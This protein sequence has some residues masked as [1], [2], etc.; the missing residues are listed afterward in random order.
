MSA[1]RLHACSRSTGS[2]TSVCSSVWQ[3]V[4]KLPSRV[5]CSSGTSA[6]GTVATIGAVGAVPSCSH[7]SER[8]APASVARKTSLIVTPSDLPTA[9]IRAS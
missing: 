7:S 2:A 1:E 3:V 6:N 8:I 4:E 5:R 9:R